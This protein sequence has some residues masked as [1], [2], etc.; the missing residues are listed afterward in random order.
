MPPTPF[1][2]VTPFNRVTI[3]VEEKVD[4]KVDDAMEEAMMKL[5]KE[6]NLIFV[7]IPESEKGNSRERAKED[8]EKVIK[9]LK[10]VI[11]EADEEEL[12]INETYR[13]GEISRN[14]PR[15]LKVE[16]DRSSTRSLI[17]RDYYKTLNR[18]EGKDKPL[19]ERIFI[20][21]DYT[22]K[23]RN[24]NLEQREELAKRRAAGETDVYIKKGKFIKETRTNTEQTHTTDPTNKVNGQPC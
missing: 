22:K 6:K 9:L 18:K 10:N 16:V 23:E 15:M 11:P 1:I 2:R 12:K 5:R 3:V 19:A 20:N 8:K 21:K 13:L 4:L 14:K 17:L 24:F 7:N